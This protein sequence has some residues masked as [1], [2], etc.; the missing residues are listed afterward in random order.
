MRT[1]EV[2]RPT[3]YQ[4]TDWNRE[5][6]SLPTGQWGRLRWDEYLQRLKI[7]MTKQTHIRMKVGV[8]GILWMALFEGPEPR[9]RRAK[10]N[11]T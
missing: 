2:K 7:S 3:T 10:K 4:I 11:Q 6:F 9:A 1:A 8:T 5:D